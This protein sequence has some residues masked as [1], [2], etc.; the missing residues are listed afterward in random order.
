[1]KKYKVIKDYDVLTKGDIFELTEN[2]TYVSKAERSDNDCVYQSTITVSL[3]YMADAIA[4]GCVIEL[5]P[6]DTTNY[7]KLYLS[8]AKNWKELYQYLVDMRDQYQ[9]DIDSVLTMFTNGE[10]EECQKL[11]RTTVL[12]NLRK[13][14]E[15]TLE[16]MKA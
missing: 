3:L 13:Q 12:A 5:N 8:Y 1:M 9:E 2:N 14:C 11:E 7:K 16:K 10:V 6:E 15:L 4:D